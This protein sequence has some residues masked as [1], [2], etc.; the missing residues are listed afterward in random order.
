MCKSYQWTKK[1]T[2]PNIKIPSTLALPHKEAIPALWLFSVGNRYSTSGGC[3]F[4]YLQLCTFLTRKFNPFSLC[5]FS[6][7]NQT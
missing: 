1:I 3:L 4:Q 5:H 6:E 7:L 2:T